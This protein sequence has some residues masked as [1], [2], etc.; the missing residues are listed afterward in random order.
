MNGEEV[1]TVC[2]DKKVVTG[3]GEYGGNEFQLNGAIKNHI[4]E[5]TIEF[6]DENKKDIILT[7]ELEDQTPNCV[8]RWEDGRVGGELTLKCGE[9]LEW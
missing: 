5:A 4:F 6:K 1:V 7:C 3:G 2:I 8:G 9:S